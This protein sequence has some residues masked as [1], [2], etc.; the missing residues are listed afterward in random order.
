MDSI[1]VKIYTVYAWDFALED[2]KQLVGCSCWGQKEEEIQ[3][4]LR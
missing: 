1:P 3:M 2:D 4:L